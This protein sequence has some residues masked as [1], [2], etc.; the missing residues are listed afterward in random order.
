MGMLIIYLTFY[1]H[2]VLS[3]A[4]SE[5]CWISAVCDG[6]PTW[7]KLPSFASCKDSSN[8]NLKEKVQELGSEVATLRTQI[9]DFENRLKDFMANP[10]TTDNM[11]TSTTTGLKTTPTTTA[12][13]TQG[14]DCFY[15]DRQHCYELFTN[16]SK[17]TQSEYKKE[18]TKRPGGDFAD[19]EKIKNI[20]DFG[21][22]LSDRRD[23]SLPNALLMKSS[24]TNV[25]NALMWGYSI[26]F[27][28]DD[29]YEAYFALCRSDFPDNPVYSGEYEYN[30]A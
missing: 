15:N 30:V 9:L 28:T 4:A 16:G 20:P 8:Y 21:K 5:S 26:V 22:M 12:T 6:T 7:M 10:S 1:A 11:R 2:T 27:T 17:R 13:P 24:I 29:E 19:Y 25:G 18:C 14:Y 3:A 23:T